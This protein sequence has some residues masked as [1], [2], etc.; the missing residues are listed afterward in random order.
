MIC[1][2][3]STILLIAKKEEV[4]FQS[5]KHGFS[6]VALTRMYILFLKYLQIEHIKYIA[7]VNK[8]TNRTTKKD[9]YQSRYA[10]P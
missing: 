6:F 7:K 5:I 3:F 2:V 8:L 10:K 4:M 9:I 1:I